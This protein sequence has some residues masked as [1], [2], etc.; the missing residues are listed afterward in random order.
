MIFNPMAVGK[1]LPDLSNPG[2]AAD[3]LQGKQLV[4]QDGN[5]LT[6]TM[7]SV[8]QATPSIS[9]SSGGLITASAAQSGG[10]V[11]AGTKSATKQLTTQGA[12]TI[13]P[14]TSNKSIASGRYLTGTQTIKGDGNLVPGNIRS[15]VSIFGV[16]GSYAGEGMR[17]YRQYETFV[18]NAGPYSI[19]CGFRPRFIIMAAT[20]FASDTSESQQKYHNFFLFRAADDAGVVDHLVIGGETAMGRMRTRDE[21]TQAYTTIGSYY[22]MTVTDSGLTIEIADATEVWDGEYLIYVFG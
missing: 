1:K 19:N 3:L 12:Q 21:R 15:G 2:A 16:T 7:P 13:T 20:D 11:A 8:V 18:D 22:P 5:V 6:G 4:D 17:I 10:N 9:V 14:G